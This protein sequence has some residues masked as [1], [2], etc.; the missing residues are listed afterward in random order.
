MYEIIRIDEEA[1]RKKSD[2][3]FVF[4]TLSFRK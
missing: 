4:L 1:T 2:W 3:E